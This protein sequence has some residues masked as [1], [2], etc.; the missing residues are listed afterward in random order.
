MKQDNDDTN[1]EISNEESEGVGESTLSSEIEDDDLNNPQHEVLHLDQV[2]LDK[3]IRTTRVPLP[4]KLSRADSVISRTSLP[5][6]RYPVRAIAPRLFK[7]QMSAIIISCETDVVQALP[8][9]KAG[10]DQ[11]VP[12]PKAGGDH[13]VLQRQQATCEVAQQFMDAVVFTRTHWPIISDEK[14]SMVEEAWTHAIYAQDRQRAFASAPVGAPPV[15][16]LASGPSHKINPQ[17]QEAVSVYSVF[18]SSVGLMMIL[19]L[20]TYIV[21]T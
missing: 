21:K 11:N 15:C 13:N 18:C 5:N 17:T 12:Q 7:R 16:Q 4:K 14:Y 1:W 6:L 2:S 8:L 19:N 9:P 20:K 3:T 10:G